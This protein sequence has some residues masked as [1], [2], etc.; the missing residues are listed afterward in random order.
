MQAKRTSRH[1]KGL[2]NKRRD[3]CGIITQN[4]H[5]PPQNIQLVE[6]HKRIALPF[7]VFPF[8]LLGLAL[9]AGPPRGSRTSGFALSLLT[10]IVFYILFFNGLRLAQVGKISAF[11]G[12]W[13]A[14]I[15]LSALAWLF[16]QE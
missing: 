6:L 15:L 2:R 16:S 4:L 12:A 11:W 3:S 9:A 13:S 7:A 1:L 10:V 8:A 14:N 5:N